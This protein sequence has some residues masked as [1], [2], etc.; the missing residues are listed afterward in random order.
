MEEIDTE[1]TGRT[2]QGTM[3][4]PRTGNVPRAGTA[5]TMEINT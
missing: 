4:E 1:F 2:T 3:I 5:G